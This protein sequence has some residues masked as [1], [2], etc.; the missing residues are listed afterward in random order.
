MQAH[1]RAAEANAEQIISKKIHDGTKRNYESKIKKVKNWIQDHELEDVR[2]LYDA[3]NDSLN[4]QL[5]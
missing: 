1:K 2:N 5:Q 3:A 4:L